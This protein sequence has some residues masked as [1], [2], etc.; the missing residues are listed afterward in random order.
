MDFDDLFLRYREYYTYRHG[1]AKYNSVSAKV[2]SSEKLD[3]CFPYFRAN[4][5]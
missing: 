1:Q 5:K 2:M 3:V 4:Q